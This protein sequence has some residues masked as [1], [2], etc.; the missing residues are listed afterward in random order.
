MSEK[1]KPPYKPSVPIALKNAAKSGTLVVFVGAGISRFAG[2]PTWDE[3]AHASLV[4]LNKKKAISYSE[5]EQL[6]GLTPKERLSIAK[7]ISDEREKPINFKGILEPKKPSIEDFEVFLNILSIGSAFVT[8]N[9]DTWLEQSFKYA[10]LSESPSVEEP[11]RKLPNQNKEVLQEV[12]VV[13]E[14]SKLTT[15]HLY[16]PGRIIHLHG[17]LYNE[18]AMIITTKQYLKHYNDNNVII[19]LEHL[20]D[21]FTVLF[22]GYG[23]K[24]LEILEY[25]FNKRKDRSSS[26]SCADHFLL[27]PVFSHDELLFRHLKKYYR[28]HC[29]VELVEYCRDE[30]DYDQLVDVLSKWANDIEYKEA[31]PIEKIN[32]IDKAFGSNE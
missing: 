28:E 8:T 22:V 3:M 20:F 5:I 4:D 13:D 11:E 9:Y 10:Y 27:F 2:S 31:S 1:F 32:L 17:S 26:D 15:D 19:F 16:K 12:V 30:K 6:K 29:N 7:D 24:E 18:D 14:V 25:V 21:R 23:M